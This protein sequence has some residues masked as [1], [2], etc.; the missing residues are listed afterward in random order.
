MNVIEV[1]LLKENL[2]KGFFVDNLYEMASI[3]EKLMK[4]S[5]RAPAFYILR[6]V[7]LDLARD[8]DER[9]LPAEEVTK[10]QEKLEMPIREVI[11]GLEA[12]WSKEALFESLRKLVA[13]R[14]EAF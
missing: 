5:A 12:L 11:E 10:V 6:S 13:A 9:P 14:I 7:F 4:D 1:Q 8:W 2:G 3:C